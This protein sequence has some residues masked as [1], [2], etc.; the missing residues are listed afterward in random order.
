MVLIPVQH[1]RLGGRWSKRQPRSGRVTH[2][3]VREHATVREFKRI[4]K[5]SQDCDEETKKIL[6]AS[7]KV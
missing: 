5:E 2:V 7:L 6:G 3:E 4:L 1:M